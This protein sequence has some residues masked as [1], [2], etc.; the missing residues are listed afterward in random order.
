MQYFL[1][2][3]QKVQ[4]FFAKN[5]KNCFLDSEQTLSGRMLVTAPFDGMQADVNT[6]AMGVAHCN[7]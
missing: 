5:A 4:L 3:M 2:K 6:K 7:A 1:Q